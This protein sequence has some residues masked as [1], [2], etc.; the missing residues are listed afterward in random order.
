MK[1]VETLYE[2]NARD[3]V[4][5]LRQSADSIERGEPSVRKMV[6]VCQHD[7]KTYSVYGWG[8]VD[9]LSALGLLHM[10]AVE[11]A[12]ICLGVPVKG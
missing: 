6:A 2:T 1:V 8:D 3:I 4:A 12:R 11:I 9:D 5:M 10:G 7:D